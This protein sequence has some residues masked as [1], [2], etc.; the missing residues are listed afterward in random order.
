M[1]LKIKLYL[2][3]FQVNCLF[4]FIYILFSYADYICNRYKEKKSYLKNMKEK[5]NTIFG[6]KN[7]VIFVTNIYLRNPNIRLCRP[8]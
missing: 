4:Y 1:A 6:I 3:F 7:V 2:C 5:N 8:N